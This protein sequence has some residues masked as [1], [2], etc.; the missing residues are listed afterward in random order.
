MLVFALVVTIR[1]LWPYFQ[2]HPMKVLIDFP[3]KKILQK[4]NAFDW[5]MKWAI[6]LSEFDIDYLPHKRIKG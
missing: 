5:L 3:L 2:A 6:E 4:P 1:R